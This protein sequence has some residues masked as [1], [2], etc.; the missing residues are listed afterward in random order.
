[1]MTT[2][3]RPPRIAVPDA[4]RNPGFRALWLSRVA[5]FAGDG[6]AQ[7]ALVLLAADRGGPRGVVLMLAA[8]AVPRLLGP[9]TGALAD[10]IE[11]RA[12]MRACE[13]VQGTLVAGLAL[14]MP[15]FPVVLAVVA[16][17]SLTMAVFTPAGRGAV[18]ALVPAEHRVAANALLSIAMTLNIAVGGAAGG[19]LVAVAGV[20][21]ALLADAVSFGVS[22]ALL[23]GVPRLP[24]HPGSAGHGYLRTV[25]AGLAHAGR[26]PLVRAVM[27]MTLAVVGLLGVDN[28]VLVF[29]A[30]D[31][32]GA[33]PTGYGLL[34]AAYG[35][36]MT[37]AS[38]VLAVAATASGRPARLATTGT[39]LS[40]AGQ[41]L[42]G[43]A[44][45]TLAAGLAQGL[46]GVGNAAENVGVDT[47]LQERVPQAMLGRVFGL[48][49]AVVQVGQL[50]ALALAVVLLHVTSPRGAFIVSAVALAVVAVPL[51]RTLLRA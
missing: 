31:D 6:I 41:F 1:M 3:A 46:C 35:L 37:A 7:V 20:R 24:P 16:A 30:R 5:S 50:L 47:L 40:V 22:A 19:L 8:T 29:L 45:A 27:F 25:R 38:A 17:M 26:S 48:L 15:P 2:M 13:L 21:G 11:Q 32:L 4:L 36:G 51:A 14:T 39:G 49:V 18:P 10:R 28:A 44:P 33:G 12:L 42:T 23:T 9:F 43:L 34:V